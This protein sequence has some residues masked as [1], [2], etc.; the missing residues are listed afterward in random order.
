[1]ARLKLDP[2]TLLEDE[3]SRVK[4]ITEETGESA[5]R[6]GRLP[7]GVAE[8]AFQDGVIIQLH[9]QWWRG[10]KVLRPEDLGMSPTKEVREFL[11]EAVA[12]GGKRMLPREILG[13]LKSCE[14]RGRQA[15]SRCSFPTLYGSFVPCTTYGT[16]RAAFETCRDDFLAVRDDILARHDEIVEE[17]RQMWAEAAPRLWKMANG[18]R[19]LPPNYA[20]DTGDRVARQIRSPED[21]MDSFAY[22]Q[23]LQLVP[24]PSEAQVDALKAEQVGRARR[25]GE[26]RAAAVMDFERDLAAEYAAKNQ[27]VKLFVD[28]IQE[29]IAS[30]ICE[31][32][33]DVHNSIAKQASLPERTVGKLRRLV[34]RA[35]QLN[36]INDPV[37]EE[38]LGR[39]TSE[40]DSKAVTAE[41]L[42]KV[43]RAVQ[44]EAKPE[45]AEARRADASFSLV[46]Q[47]DDAE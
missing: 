41:S 6:I 26:E 16:W 9:C 14:V 1:M 45:I 37:A 33:T 13:K 15:L 42:Q 47:L 2:A 39:I 38:W 18:Q 31:L 46:L 17:I 35:R 29:Q 40:M 32:A 43:L 12:L 7:E 11:A 34:D 5:D 22:Y 27:Q 21:I 10:H 30:A 25:L 44:A 24:I 19:P 28:G 20:A 23:T 8:T 3:G 36:F 4:R